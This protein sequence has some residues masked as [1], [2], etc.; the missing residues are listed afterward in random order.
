M[1]R[2]TKFTFIFT[3]FFVLILHVYYS[4][5]PAVNIMHVYVS[6]VFGGRWLARAPHVCSLWNGSWGNVCIRRGDLGE[7]SS[8]CVLPAAR[9]LEGNNIMSGSEHALSR[10]VV[11]YLVEQGSGAE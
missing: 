10:L 8:L 6:R 9:E 1:K 3:H 7:R 11:V 4:L 5:M 2:T